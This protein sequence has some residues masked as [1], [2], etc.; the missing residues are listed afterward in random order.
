[1]TAVAY[2]PRGDVLV[3]AALDGTT[4]V[5]SATTGA[6]IRVLPP[7]RGHIHALA[8]SPDGEHLATAVWGHYGEADGD[9]GVIVRNTRTWEI[10]ARPA[11]PPFGALSVAYSPD[12][13]FLAVANDHRTTVFHTSRWVR[14]WSESHPAL[15]TAVAFMDRGVGAADANGII[16][17]RSVK[18][19]RLLYDPLTAYEGRVFA[20]ACNHDQTLLAAAGQR[21]HSHLAHSIVGPFRADGAARPV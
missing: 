4:H 21:C 12:G 13:R 7:L 6:V 16:T 8:F 20:L 10:V 14:V 2:H 3:S 18:T 15:V 1:M 19:G 11:L 17:F 9:R 5:R